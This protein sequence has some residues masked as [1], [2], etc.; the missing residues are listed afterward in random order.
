MAFAFVMR[1]DG[2][3][4][5]DEDV[6]PTNRKGILDVVVEAGLEMDHASDCN[7]EQG[8]EHCRCNPK[9]RGYGA[10]A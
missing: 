5:F 1:K 2:T 10:P 6:S 7:H 8:H 9:V 4:P 3:I